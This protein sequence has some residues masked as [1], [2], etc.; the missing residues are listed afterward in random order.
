VTYFNILWIAYWLG[1]AF[2][3]AIAGI[4]RICGHRGKAFRAFL[5]APAAGFVIFWL[6]HLVYL[7][8]VKVPGP[9]PHQSHEE[10][11]FLIM[12]YNLYSFLFEGLAPAMAYK[13]GLYF[14]PVI[15]GGISIP[16][17]FI[18]SFFFP[19]SSTPAGAVAGEKRP[20]SV[21]AAGKSGT[22]S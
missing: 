6:T 15:Y 12:L 5:V 22:D 17:A 10:G 13:L 21:S 20:A 19:L 7:L 18:S 2:L 8:V 16:I 9:A 14:D 1:L 3:A 4:I 11:D